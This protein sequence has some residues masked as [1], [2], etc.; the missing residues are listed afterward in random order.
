MYLNELSRYDLRAQKYITSRQK[1]LLSKL[2]LFSVSDLLTYFPFRYEDRT[3][4]ESIRESLTKNKPVTVVVT[5]TGHQS[6]FYNRKS[7]PK[8]SVQDGESQAFLIGFHR[9]YL[10]QSLRSEERRV[11]KEC[12]S[13]WSP[14]H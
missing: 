6:I 7:H 2:D 5:V 13:R 12:R 8:I 4:I 9:P 11:G 3:Q 1:S 14:Y 10:L